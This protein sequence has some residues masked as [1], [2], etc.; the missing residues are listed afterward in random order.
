MSNIINNIFSELDDLTKTKSVTDYAREYKQDKETKL[1]N[2]TLS[3]SLTQGEKFKKYQKQIKKNTVKQNN[4]FKPNNILKQ[5]DILE[6]FININ[7]ENDG[8][9]QQ[10]RDVLKNTNISSQQRTA[11]SSLVTQ[12]NST[13]TSYQT[14]IGEITGMTDDY[15][16]R[17]NP[18]N[19]YLNKTIKFSGG[20]MAYV[21]N[22]GIVKK[23]ATTAILT[24]TGIP[25][26]FTT[27]TIPWL[28]SYNIEGTK[29]A[30][31]PPLIIGT[32]L[33]AN[34]SVGNEGRNI[35]VDTLITNTDATYQGCYAD[36]VASPIMTFIGGAPPVNSG[37]QN[38]NFVQ[39]Q[40]ANNSYRYITSSSYV[41]GWVFN[42]CIINNSSAWG[43][44]IPYPNG[45]QCT[46]IQGT[47]SLSQTM[48]LSI[49]TYT[50]HWSACGRGPFSD[51]G[52]S[53]LILVSLLT[54]NQKISVYRCEPPISSWEGYTTTINVLT[55]GQNTLTFEGTWPTAY[56]ST[57]IQGITLSS[58][59]GPSSGN[60][61]YD[62]CKQSAIN[63]EY[64]YFALQN[65]NSATSKGF[66]AVTNN[67]IAAT[68][69]GQSYV[70]TGAT[71]LWSSNTGGQTG[72]TA[73]LTTSGSL[74]VINSGDSSVYASPSTNATPANYIGCY[75]DNPWRALPLLNTDGTLSYVWGGSKWDNTVASAATYARANNYKY[76]SVQ[77]ANTSL[78]Q[79]QAGFSNN[80]ASATRYGKASN[81]NKVN[82]SYVGVGGG[83]S[84]AV[85]SADGVS[86]N[87]FLIL[88][89][90]GN[91]GVYRGTG[92]YDNQGYI[93]D[94]KTNGKQRNS[95]PNYAAAKG[96]YGKNWIAHDQP[97]AAGEFVG[98][99]SGSIYL[100]MQAD[101]NL[102]LYTSTN[103]LNCPTMTD[104]R[105][106][107]GQGANALYKMD[108]TGIKNNMGQLAYVDDDS[109]LF[110]YPSSN[111]HSTNLY[112]KITGVDS[113][114]NDIA[115]AA[116]YASGAID[117]NEQCKAT[118]NANPN[119]Y[120]YVV[121]NA[122]KACYPKTN[123]MYP[124][125]N[126][127]TLANADTYTR[128]KGPITTPLGVPT[129]VNNTDTLRFSKYRKSGKQIGDSYGLANA[130]SAQKQRL[131]QLQNQL[132]V[133]SS[134][135]NEK[136]TKY[137]NDNAAVNS[138][139]ETNVAGISD[140]LSDIQTTN[141]HIAGFDTN[142][143]NMLKDSDIKA[144]QK[145]YN[146]L[147]W[148]ILTAGTVLVSMNIVK[149]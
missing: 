17:I 16:A 40:I 52:K 121:D 89:D 20:E 123:R 38:G 66:C 137:S 86:S 126:L 146:Y 74:N 21:T 122:N 120:G 47:Q 92:P 13:L 55:T 124:T 3:A 46:S 75:R 4:E 136:T 138:Q 85:Y 134:Q 14:L 129:T 135:L 12:Y 111:I 33:Q 41:P 60:Y 117:T 142:V 5:D 109:N 53:N 6:G 49:G 145:N 39:P 30:T 31:T 143:D 110:T 87:Y 71:S 84:N 77:A 2:E 51:N 95:N 68:R 19:P 29:V 35:F 83:W 44:P 98:S 70:P 104:T 132:N 125:G 114:G 64:Q 57:A 147:F 80:L 72:N 103:V 34:Q 90:D 15:L 94:T 133:L 140:Y 37:L 149:K 22:L 73:K 101:G 139:T 81:C 113:G 27:L 65:V 23:V 9:T 62:M 36:N 79:G 32:P 10:S 7:T 43:Y 102:V 76:F 24:S 119:C 148:S 54:G 63:G 69:N 25:T 97:L 118:C 50:L 59:G 28:A 58:N 141:E 131:S 45:N 106:G 100:I 42:A 11:L 144:L 88:Q 96:K 1:N 108:A 127:Q 116:Y 107:G 78:G 61:T 99:T 93:W 82:N 128:N 105:V 18:S 8:L 67:S 26:T 48:N 112:T 56:R 91:M 115:G 130:T